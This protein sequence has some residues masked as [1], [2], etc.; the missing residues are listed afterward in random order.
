MKTSA[1]VIP[2]PS[3]TLNQVSP[4]QPAT[5]Q[6]LQLLKTSGP[7]AKQGDR[8]TIHYRIEA[9]GSLISDTATTGL[10]FQF[11]IGDQRVPSFLS[12][13]AE[14]LSERST[15][16]FIVPA[17]LAGGDQ[18]KPPLMPPKQDLRVTV[19]LVKLTPVE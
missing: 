3:P 7:V 9:N 4:L 5:I 1:L 14:G 8:V 16:I 18:G 12:L 15:R 19:R 17:G 10:P 6:T 2:K 11:V 13:G